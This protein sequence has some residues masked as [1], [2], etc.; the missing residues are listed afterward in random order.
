MLAYYNRC[1]GVRLGGQGLISLQW[2]GKQHEKLKAKLF[3]FKNG[4]QFWPSYRTNSRPIRLE[5]KQFSML[6]RSL[7]KIVIRVSKGEQSLSNS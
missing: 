2:P 5:L 6:W 3:I 4:D 7:P 1:V